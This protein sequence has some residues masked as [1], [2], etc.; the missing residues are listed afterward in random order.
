[1]K[2]SFIIF[3]LILTFFSCSDDPIISEQDNYNSI[4]H[5]QKWF[6][7]N[8]SISSPLNGRISSRPKNISWKDGISYA[9]DKTQTVEV[10]IQY[11]TE[12]IAYPQNTNKNASYK[13]LTKLLMFDDGKGGYNIFIMRIMPD[14][15]SLPE[16]EKNNYDKKV[17][18]FTGDIIYYTWEGSPIVYARYENGKRIEWNYIEQASKNGDTSGARITNECYTIEVKWYQIVCIDGY[19]SS[20]IYLGSDYYDYCPIGSIPNYDEDVYPGDLYGGGSS[21][22]PGNYQPVLDI[23]TNNLTTPCLKNIISNLTNKNLANDINIAINKI[24]NNNSNTNLIIN[25]NPNLT[26]QNTGQPIPATTNVTSN[27]NP[28]EVTMTL[29][30]TMLKS[31]SSEYVAATVYHE[32]MHAYLNTLPD[33]SRD[34][35]EQHVEMATSYVN[36]LIGALQEVFPNLNNKTAAGLA[37]RGLGDMM[38]NNPSYWNS[39]IQGFEFSNNQELVTLTDSYR[40]GGNTGTPCN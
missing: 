2:K 30:P 40:D 37:L 35:L 25:E 27:G 4:E 38:R 5:A 15:S 32:A 9:K 11:E 18:S 6:E 28:F 8:V 23:I 16:L 17:N 20:P 10:P 22:S 21:G 29:N 33:Q 24:F 12:L 39:L 14:I 26:S 3:G 36:W 7:Q 19:C 13:N 31:S 34:Q 1:M